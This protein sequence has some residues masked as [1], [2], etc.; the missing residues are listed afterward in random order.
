MKIFFSAGDP[1]GD[2]NCAKVVSALKKKYPDAKLSGL[3][4]PA[5][6]KAGLVSDFDFAKFGK[7]G[8]WEVIKTLPFFI[9]AQKKFIENMKRERPEILLCVDFSGFNQRL[10]LEA[11]KLGIKVLWFIAPMIW[12]WKRK[13]YIKFF[14][15][16]K[17]HIACI[18][19]FE[20]KHWQPEIQSVSFV[21]NPLLELLDYSALPDKEPINPKE[22]F[23]VALLPGSRKQEIENIMPFMLDC[24]LALK[25]LYPKVKIIISKTSYLP[26]E[27]YKKT[28]NFGF[29]FESDFNKI[30]ATANLA[31]VASG[32]ASLQL[33]LAA[34]PHIV[35]YKTSAFTFWLFKRIIKEKRFIGLS[36]IVVQR[37]V[38][39]E[40]IQDEMLQSSVL[41]AVRAVIENP[42]K[43]EKTMQELK[44]L[45]SLLGD[46]K[47]SEEVVKLIEKFME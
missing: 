10:V 19:P 24:A 43:Y 18:F 25:I 30:L 11:N 40:F 21:G 4:G 27:A 7:M 39:P 26:E 17:A 42:G 16:H 20:P 6:Q 38:V 23:T 13:K 12:V 32:T 47:A 44:S 9:L 1:S 29:E 2:V 15:K 34:V 14:E 45:R 28:R 31:L 3:G 46:K 8:Y 35:L 5:M 36:N 41:V 33:G 37:S 22:E